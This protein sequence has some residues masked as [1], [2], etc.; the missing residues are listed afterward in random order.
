MESQADEPKN[1]E[2]FAVIYQ[3]KLTIEQLLSEV[4][5]KLSR[6]AISFG[7]KSF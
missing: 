1:A 6:F 4:D 2:T 3:K 7:G 5:C